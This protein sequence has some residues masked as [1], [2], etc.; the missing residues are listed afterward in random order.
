VNHIERARSWLGR[1]ET[2]EDVAAPAPI[3]ALYDLIDARDAPPRVGEDAPPLAHWLYFSSW[4]RLQETN[5]SGDYR[6]PALPP[7]ELPRRLCVGARVVFHRPLRVG[8]RISRVMRVADVAGY[9][10]GAGPVVTVLLRCE[11]EDAEGLI[12]S[13][14]RRLLYMSRREAWPGEAA[15]SSPLAA[16]WSAPFQPNTRSLFRYA[17]LTHDMN[18]L[19]YDRP[20]AVFVERH[21]GLVVPGGLIAARLLAMVREHAPHARPRQLDLRVLNW[22]Y[23][24]KPLSLRAGWRGDG[25]IGVFAEDAEG[26]LGFEGS[27]AV[28]TA[29]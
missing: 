5:E 14:E 22:L 3:A 8:A 25:V 19:H 20:F 9:E 13:E 24:V 2:R 29:G 27:L 18:R 16:D 23:D 26:R 28:E 15:R 10:G 21:P 6:D 7:I 17:A 1:V 11:I 4:S 12:L